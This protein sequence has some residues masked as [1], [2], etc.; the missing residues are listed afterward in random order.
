MATW[1]HRG[2]DVEI[3]GSRAL[4]VILA[5]AQGLMNFAQKAL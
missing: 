5:T 1:V 3:L 4:E 2:A